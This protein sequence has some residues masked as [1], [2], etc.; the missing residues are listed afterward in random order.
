MLPSRDARAVDATM[1][2]NDT[3]ADLIYSICGHKP[4]PTYGVQLLAKDTQ[5]DL[6]DKIT[7]FT[8]SDYIIYRLC[9]KIGWKN[10]GGNLIVRP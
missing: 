9:G 1:R 5:R 3:C 4:C 8:L 2:L 7:V 6:Y 10:T